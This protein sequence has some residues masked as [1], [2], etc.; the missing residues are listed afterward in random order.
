MELL[1]QGAEARIFQDGSVIIKER[2]VKTYRHDT[3][4]KTLRE[5]RTRREAVVLRTLAKA[6]FP[7][8][9]LIHIDDKKGLLSI[10]RIK[11]EKLSL[12]LSKSPQRFGAQIGK[13]LAVLHNTGIVHG[14]PT[15]S[16]MIVGADG[17]ITLID[18]GLSQFSKKIED[19]A[20]DLHLLD[21][22]IE[23]AHH[24]IHT[25]V[26]AAAIESYQKESKDPERILQRLDAVKKRGRNKMKGS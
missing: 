20:V 18:F 25:T 4:D 26:M 16:N 1:A 22:A 19:K 24:E 6:G 15:T 8:P 12:E 11:G 13:L 23:S 21:R 3:I 2:T 17:K 9:T 7:S 10:E 14:D 5:G